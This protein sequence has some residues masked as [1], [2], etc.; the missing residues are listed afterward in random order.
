MMAMLL[1]V[2]A[3]LLNSFAGRLLGKPVRL[4]PEGR[5][6]QREEGERA[7]AS[8]HVPSMHCQGCLRTIR[9]GLASLPGV[10]AVDGDVKAKR[11]RV[12]YRPDR[13]DETRICAR[14]ST[15]G[16]DASCSP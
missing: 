9:E 12:L 4:E 14:L 2:T 1:S 10:E 3:V 8:F 15:L 6:G 5:K 13:L 7:M 16:F 11:V